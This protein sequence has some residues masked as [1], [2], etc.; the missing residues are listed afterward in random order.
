[1]NHLMIDKI[2]LFGFQLNQKILLKSI[3]YITKIYFNLTSVILFSF[4][5]L[6]IVKKKALHVQKLNQPR[7]FDY[8]RSYKNKYFIKY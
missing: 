7:V 5:L 4:P 8:H 3:P 2:I 6:R 1:M